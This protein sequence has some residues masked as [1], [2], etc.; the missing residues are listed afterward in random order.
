MLTHWTQQ[1]NVHIVLFLQILDQE[2]LVYC[3]KKK[4]ETET[5]KNKQARS[6]HNKEKKNADTLS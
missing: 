5:E 3:L 1:M 2:L 4:Q 6:G